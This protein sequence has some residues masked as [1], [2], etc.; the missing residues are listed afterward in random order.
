M[1]DVVTEGNKTVGHHGHAVELLN[2]LA[3]VGVSQ[4]IVGAIEDFP[5]GH[6][7]KLSE[8]AFEE[9]YA[10]VDACLSLDSSL[11]YEIEHPWMSSKMPGVGLLSGELRTV[12]AGLLPCA[13]SDHLAIERI[14]D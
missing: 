6:F 5:Q 9:A 11:E 1:V 10:P 12:N 7:F 3:L 13:D 4:R 8:V 2:P 14:A